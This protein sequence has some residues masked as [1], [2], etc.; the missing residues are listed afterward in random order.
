[1]SASKTNP[2]QLVAEL[3]RHPENFVR[4]QGMSFVRI[5]EMR[6]RFDK[7][8]RIDCVEFVRDGKVLFSRTIE[9]ACGAQPDLMLTLA[10]PLMVSV[11]LA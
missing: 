11:D 6:L 10:S 1:M 2:A 5:D 9:P 8:S 3:M 4:N 7:F